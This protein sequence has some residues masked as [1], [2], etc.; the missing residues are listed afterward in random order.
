ME[1]ISTLYIKHWHYE[2]DTAKKIEYYLNKGIS[3]IDDEIRIS[4]FANDI[5]RIHVHYKGF[6]FSFTYIYSESGYL[7]YFRGYGKTNSYG[8]GNRYSDKEQKDREKSYEYVKKTIRNF[9]DNQKGVVY[10]QKNKK[11]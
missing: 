8:F 5:G 9:L 1:D 2:N 3:R 7:S 11:I 4:V 6:I 10:E